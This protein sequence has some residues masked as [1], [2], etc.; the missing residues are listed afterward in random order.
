M[1]IVPTGGMSRPTYGRY[2][3]SVKQAAEAADQRDVAKARA[4]D[5][6]VG[7]ESELVEVAE[8]QREEHRHVEK[9]ASDDDCVIVV[10][11]Q[12]RAEEHHCYDDRGAVEEA[13][14]A[15]LPRGDHTEETHRRQREQDAAD[16][17]EALP[18]WHSADD[19]EHEGADV[20][21]PG[22]GGEDAKEPAVALA[23]GA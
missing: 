23:L 6:R 10:G 14:A 12:H 21:K 22:V 1:R 17:I 13:R 4:F 3:I 2:S 20:P 9:Q 7:L 18:E 19:A 16:Q 11:G 8:R 15:G 5:A